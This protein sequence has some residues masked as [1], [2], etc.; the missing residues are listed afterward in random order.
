MV[1]CRAKSGYVLLTLL[2]D[3][4][5]LPAFHPQPPPSCANKTQISAVTRRVW[6]AAL[7]GC[8]AG[9]PLSEERKLRRLPVPSRLSWKHGLRLRKRWRPFPGKELETVSVGEV[10]QPLL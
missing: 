1:E 3:A 2:F 4:N 9:I 7:G 8:P 5:A 10:G 6:A